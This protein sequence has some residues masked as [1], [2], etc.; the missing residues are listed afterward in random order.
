MNL[1]PESIRAIDAIAD[2]VGVLSLYGD[3]P[4]AARRSPADRALALR[5][6]L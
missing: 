6:R 1:T 3:G 4:A 5:R 2:P